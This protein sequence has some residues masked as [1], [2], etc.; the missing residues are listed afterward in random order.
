MLSLLITTTKM[1]HLNFFN[2][3][4]LAMHVRIDFLYHAILFLGVIKPELRHG[5][6]A[7]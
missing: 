6:I 1:S 5:I 7:C 4:Q 2:R 3:T